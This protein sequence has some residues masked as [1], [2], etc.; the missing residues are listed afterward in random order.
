MGGLAVAS[1]RDWRAQAAERSTMAHHL[2]NEL[3]LQSHYIWTL[4]RH[5]RQTSLKFDDRLVGCETGNSSQA[6]KK[7]IKSSS[8]PLHDSFLDNKNLKRT[9][10]PL[11]FRIVFN[12]KKLPIWSRGQNLVLV[13]VCAGE[14]C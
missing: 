9:L 6:H 4:L 10:V 2:G 11:T 13:W 8:T 3:Q 7:Q 12:G 1:S 14:I 5:E